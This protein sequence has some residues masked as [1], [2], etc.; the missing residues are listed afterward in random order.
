MEI[1]CRKCRKEYLVD[2]SKWDSGHIFT[3]H[4]CINEEFEVVNSTITDGYKKA[5]EALRRLRRYYRI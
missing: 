5:K 3:C 1:R 2:E 4:E